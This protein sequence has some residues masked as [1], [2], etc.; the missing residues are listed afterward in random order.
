MSLDPGQGGNLI[1]TKWSEVKLLSHVRLCATPWT[2]AHQAPPSMGFSRQEYWGGLP[3]PSPGDLPDPGIEPRSP[4]LQ[5]DALTSEP[6]GKLPYEDKEP[7]SPGSAKLGQGQAGVDWGLC[8]DPGHCPA[9][10]L[11]AFEKQL[12]SLTIL[13]VWEATVG[14]P[15]WLKPYFLLNGSSILHSAPPISLQPNLRTTSGL[16]KTP[17]FVWGGK[18]LPQPLHQDH[19][20]WHIPLLA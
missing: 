12:S 3:F 13:S 7:I 9:W 16:V 4:A 14:S 1:K 17:A 15:Q 6:P 8:S 2:V 11:A 20:G 5:A 19:F 18:M 10:L